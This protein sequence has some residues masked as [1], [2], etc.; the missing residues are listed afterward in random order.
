[1]CA[2]SALVSGLRSRTRRSAIARRH[3]AR[4][5]H[6]DANEASP[7]ER[8]EN[9]ELA[10]KARKA[11]LGRKRCRL[12]VD[13]AGTAARFDE[14][15][16]FVHLAQ[17]HAQAR[18]LLKVLA[19]RDVPALARLLPDTEELRERLVAMDR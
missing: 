2:T 6:V 7:A 5:A 18:P 17:G 1:M 9:G 16:G 3:N 10:Q 12:V 15:L 8:Q 11:L 14:Q 4:L 19:D 13:A